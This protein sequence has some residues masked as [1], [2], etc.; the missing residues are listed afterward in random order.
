MPESPSNIVHE[1]MK[2]P[3]QAKKNHG[4]APIIVINPVAIP[5]EYQSR[6]DSQCLS[7]YLFIFIFLIKR[8]V[9]FIIVKRDDYSSEKCRSSYEKLKKNEI[10]EISCSNS[11]VCDN[12]VMV[13]SFYSLIAHAAVGRKRWSFNLTSTTKSHSMNMELIARTIF[14]LIL[15]RCLLHNPIFC[16]FKS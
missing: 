9:D 15:F 11:A 16:F 6:R 8:F 3:I 14:R 12:S 5:A 10:P 4:I 2:K 7:K 1:D 13:E